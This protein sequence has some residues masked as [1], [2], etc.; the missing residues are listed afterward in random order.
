MEKFKI[1]WKAEY[2]VD[3]S[4]YF[5]VNRKRALNWPHEYLSFLSAWKKPG[6]FFFGT[7]AMQIEPVNLGVKLKR[8]SILEYSEKISLAL[9]IFHVVE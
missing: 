5:A 8:Q 9:I 1:V 6:K 3:V 4:F 7:P 2:C